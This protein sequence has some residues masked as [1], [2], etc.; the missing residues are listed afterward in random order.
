[1]FKAVSSSVFIVLVVVVAM[2]AQQPVKPPQPAKPQTPPAAPAK[3]ATP[4]AQ[5]PKPAAKPASS[6]EQ[7]QRQIQATIEATD[8]A[9]N[10][11]D[12]QAMAALFTDE[13]EIVDEDGVV[14]QGRA[15]IAAV[16]AAV[17]EES[18]KARLETTVDSLRFI[19]PSVA[20]EEGRTA[21]VYEA[22]EPPVHNRYVVVHVKQD[23]KWLMASARD[24]PSP[25]TAGDEQMQQLAW[26]I[27]DWVD[28]SEDSLVLT[29]YRWTDNQNYILSEFT[30]HVA[31]HPAMSGS[32]RLTW[33]PLAKQIRSWVFDSE[34]G[35]GEGLW[36]R[37]GNQWIVK[38]RSITRDGKVA[39][40]TNIVTML[41]KDRLT[42]QSRDRIVGGERTGD[43]D[44][45]LI[46][47]RPPKP[48]E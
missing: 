44:E 21:A 7:D 22:D 47:R 9:F 27:G 32:Q 46:V 34:G 11:H 18:P 17:F 35:F 48:G 41:S 1:M 6:R 38:M 31:G 8:K 43:I 28:E 26:L 23:G 40:A 10:E 5:A 39:S 2:F 14:T 19:S 36:S 45:V 16:F 3:P 12:A 29:S 33:D 20:I 13:G 25:E 37:D 30:V 42:W 4:P 15:E 24:F